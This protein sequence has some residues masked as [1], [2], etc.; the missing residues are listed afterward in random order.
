MA[1]LLLFCGTLAK[2]QSLQMAQ[3]DG[4]VAYAESVE[5]SGATK[6]QLIER[7]QH[8]MMFNQHT[9]SFV[10]EE[11]GMI[12]IASSIPFQ[13]V[14]ANKKASVDGRIVFVATLLF[15]D[16][17]FVYEFNNFYHEADPKSSRPIDLGFV[18]AFGTENKDLNKEWKL[19]VMNE[20][21]QQIDVVV[22]KNIDSLKKTLQNENLSFSLN[23]NGK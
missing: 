4:M 14:T 9:M 15:Q 7:A 1:M 23:V 18:T 11:M 12:S 13:S 21:R 20:I 19:A 10:S 3:T 6:A 17:V 22:Q 16:G 8:W 5:V 2:A